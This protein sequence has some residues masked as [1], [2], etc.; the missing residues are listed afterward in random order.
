M[1]GDVASRIEQ[2]LA[3]APHA[4]VGASS[5]RHKF[6]NMVLRAYV[7]AGRAVHPVN[8][9]GGTIEGLAAYANLAAIQEQVHGVSIVT[10][11]K[12]TER[13][14][15]EAHARGI[16]HVWMQPGAESPAAVA[17]AEALGMNVI[18]GGPCLL[19]ELGFPGHG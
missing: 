2:F 12:V 16:R 19:V 15:E 1:G 8:P 4:V 9:S 10:P 3:G 6:G 11:P 13:I 18:A 17:R 5:D 7:H 14:I